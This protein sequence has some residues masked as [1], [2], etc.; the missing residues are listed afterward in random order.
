MS[1]PRGFAEYRPQ[2]RAQGLID[3]VNQ[4][5]DQL[6]DYLPLTL[7]QVFYRLV[8]ENCIGKTEKEHARLIETCNRARC[9]RLINFDAIRDDGVRI[10]SGH[11]FETEAELV[12]Y[13]HDVA[14]TARM[15]VLSYQDKR[16]EVWCEAAGM[17]P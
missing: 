10:E 14:A 9:A 17:V 4:V 8:V 15:D 2:H 7:R 6:S 13:L 1:R 16:V 5:L 12:E 11:D 3:A